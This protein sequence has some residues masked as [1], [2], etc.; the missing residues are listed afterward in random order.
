MVKVYR[1]GDIF[2]NENSSF[3]DENKY[4]SVF[5]YLDA[6]LIKEADKINYVLKVSDGR[7]KLL[8]L[9]LEPFNLIIYGDHDCLE[10]LLMFIK[11][12]N[13]KIKDVMC[14]EELGNHLIDVS[15]RIFHKHYQKQIG[16]DFMKAT[17]YTEDSSKEVEIPSI[18][19][20]NEL[21]ECEVNFIKDCG[22]SDKPNRKK[23]IEKIPSLRIIRKDNR[24]VSMCGRSPDTDESIRISLVYTRPEY[25][26]QGLA[27][28]VV[29]YLKNEI[30]NEGKIATLNV[31]QVNPISYH[32]YQSLGFK[33]VFSQGIYLLKE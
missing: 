18:D 22:L 24:I 26:G 10:E 33:K 32:L 23:L 12:N 31:D 27:R 25:R 16:M 17:E 29:N 9:K 4:M 5:F 15:N 3:L 6:P 2:L 7:K 21:F 1:N 28:K 8:A 20:V 13:Y 11:D 19:D 30:L 14:S